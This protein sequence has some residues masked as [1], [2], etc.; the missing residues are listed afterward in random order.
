MFVRSLE[1]RSLKQ[2]CVLNDK[3]Y[4]STFASFFGPIFLDSAAASGLLRLLFSLRLVCWMTTIWMLSLC[5]QS[6]TITI[7]LKNLEMCV[8]VR[9]ETALYL[10]LL[11]LLCICFNLSAMRPRWSNWIGAI[12][13]GPRVLLFGLSLSFFHCVT[14]KQ[15]ALYF[16]FSYS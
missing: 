8:V 11:S 13:S 5:I 1:F 3:S 15:S 12:L 6:M 9:G 10:L 7:Q 14:L 16:Q 2:N 4:N